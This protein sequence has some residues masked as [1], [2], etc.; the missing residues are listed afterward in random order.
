G[1][2]E[3]FLF[4]GGFRLL[5]RGRNG[6]GK[7]LF[8]VLSEKGSIGR[9]VVGL[10][11]L[12]F[13]DAKNIRG[14]LVT[15]K[16]VLA[17][18]RAQE[19]GQSLNALHDENE[20]ILPFKREDGVDKIMPRTAIPQI[21]FQAVGEEGEEI[22]IRPFSKT[23]AQTTFQHNTNDTQSRTAKREGVFRACGLF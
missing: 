23:N 18:F 3:I 11:V 20:I 15:G 7:R 8:F 4:D 5:R 1:G 17:I 12:L 14:A 6:G 19:V 22:V 10:A 16:Q 13:L 9:G 21:D 2:G